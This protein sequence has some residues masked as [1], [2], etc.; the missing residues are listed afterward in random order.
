MDGT[1]SMLSYRKTTAIKDLDSSK[2]GNF[3]SCGHEGYE[4]TPKTHYGSRQNNPSINDHGTPKHNEPHFT[5]EKTELSG[6]EMVTHM[7]HGCPP[8]TCAHSLSGITP[9]SREGGI[10]M[11]SS[12]CPIF[13]LNTEY[14]NSL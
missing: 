12:Q 1:Q 5:G 9:A 13:I 8:G 6:A 7:S 2:E 10:A 3:L 4:D 11:T 14:R